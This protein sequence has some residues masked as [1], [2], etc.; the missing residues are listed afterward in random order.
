MS[1]RQKRL[2]LLGSSALMLL[3]LAGAATSQ[4]RDTAPATTNPPES[5]PTVPETPASQTPQPPAAT[6]PPQST[7]AAPGT[8][9]VPTVTV[10]PPPAPRTP[11]R[12][13]PAAPAPSPS[14]ERA[15]R[16]PAPPQRPASP[17]T[18]AA[19]SATPT[20]TLDQ[21]RDNIFAPIGTAPTT[22]SREAIEAVPQG[23]NPTV[24]N[25]L[26]QFPGVSQDSAEGGNIHIRNEHIY[27]ASFRINGV[28]L[29]D[30]LG[31]FGQYM[32]P[33]FIGSLTLITG[34]LPA[35]YGM[36]TVGIIDIKTASFD[37]S[38]QIGVY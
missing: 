3:C 38:G 12:Q 8:V 27:N 37:N 20:Q 30:G 15:V 19:E 4:T 22:W 2:M 35:Q 9:P 6:P 18:P 16:A 26:L 29:P 21:R 7:P 32:D 31:G 34:A 1:M 33:S 10:T 36:R 5:P 28:L 23:S 17:P 25:V 13:P 24:E 14:P 11:L